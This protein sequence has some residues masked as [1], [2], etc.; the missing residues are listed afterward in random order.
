MRFRSANTI[1][2]R[3]PFAAPILA[4]TLLAAPTLVRA[5]DLYV[6]NNND[7]SILKFSDGT[8]SV[9]ASTY[10]SDPID[11]ALGSQDTLY[12]ANYAAGYVSRFTPGGVGSLFASGL[13]RPLYIATQIPE[14]SA[15]VLF[16]LGLPAALACRRPRPQET[17]SSP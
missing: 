1:A 9:F 8:R 4:V 6:V 17:V 13:N 15:L 16:A 7:S 5:D 3:A 2:C 14:P 12:V 11:L 10:L